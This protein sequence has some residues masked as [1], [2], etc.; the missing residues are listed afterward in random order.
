[1]QERKMLHLRPDF[2]DRFRCKAAACGH[3]CCRGWEI[4]IDENTLDLY[5]S[6]GGIWKEKMDA[7][8]ICDDSGAHFCL[9]E[10]ERCPFLQQDG[11]CELICVL[12]EDALC[13]ICAL[14]PRFY[15]SV[16]RYELA[17]LGLSCEAVCELLLSEEGELTLLCE[18]TGERIGFPALL[19][20][21]GLETG[22]D[23]LYFRPT[24]DVREMLRRLERTEP[25]DE[26]WIEELCLLREKVEEAPA[27]EIPT[28]ARY[29]RML[30]YV[31]YRSLEHAETAGWQTVRNYARDSI[32]FVALMDAI[33]GADPE[34]L[35]R[36]S[37]QIEYSTENV[38][39][40]LG[41]GK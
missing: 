38:E 1:M 16:D 10:D 32:S 31:L 19:N 3:S 22:G 33:Y 23:T 13:D 41:G 20:A 4:D 37:E 5:Q 18:E 8:V 12:G 17:G 27:P 29:D 9:T 28:G 24:A 34:H 39:L 40:L 36:W 14:H 2:F 21:L 6:L 35:R 11:L 7:A 15:E 25:I 26:A 30:Q